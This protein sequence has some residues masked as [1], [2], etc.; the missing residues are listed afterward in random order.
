MI[1]TIKGFM[2]KMR[3]NLNKYTDHSVLESNKS[4]ST[5]FGM[6][7]VPL[8]RQDETPNSIIPLLNS[9]RFQV[10]CDFLNHIDG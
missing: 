2:K 1:A 9:S 8:S 7:F 10:S 6:V 5:A 3:S 4:L